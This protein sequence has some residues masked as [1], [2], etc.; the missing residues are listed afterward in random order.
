MASV[1]WEPE[2]MKPGNAAALEARIGRVAPG[3]VVKLTLREGE[4]RVRALMPAS[5]CTRGSGFDARDRS[6]A[7]ADMLDE[8]GCPA[9][10][11]PAT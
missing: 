8:A 1:V 7:V 3:A 5:F 11:H 6:A 9:R 2:T 10:P 4:W